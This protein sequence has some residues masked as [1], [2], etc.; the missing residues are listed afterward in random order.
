MESDEVH[1]NI[2]VHLLLNLF[3]CDESLA[4]SARKI[5]EMGLELLKEV[6]LTHLSTQSH[7]FEPQGATVIFLLAESHLSIHTW[8]EKGLIACDLFCCTDKQTLDQAKS[9][10]ELA[11]EKL[12]S[13]FK[14]TKSESQ[15]VLR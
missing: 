5:E 10:V 11:A 9:K 1:K 6:G 15:I 7:Q 14:S 2:G 12:I 13:F 4:T 8:P 3:G